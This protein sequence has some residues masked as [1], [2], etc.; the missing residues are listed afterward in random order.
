M[1]TEQIANL[2]NQKGFQVSTHNHV[3]TVSL[4]RKVN[5][6]EVEIA[7]DFEVESCHIWRDGNVVKVLGF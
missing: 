6:M 1:T 2:L 4:K 5:I 3:V 7:L